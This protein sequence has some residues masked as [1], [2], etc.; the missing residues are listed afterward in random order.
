MNYSF[1]AEVV[2]SL[3]SFVLVRAPEALRPFGALL[4]VLIPLVEFSVGLGLLTRKFRDAAV[5]LAFASHLFI[6][7]LFIPP[8]RNTVVWP[9]N[10]A[11]PALVFILFWRGRN[12]SARDIL[13]NGGR[14]F[15]V[16]AL[17]LFLLAPALGLFGHW[18]SYLSAALYAGNTQRATLR[19]GGPVRDALPPRV[20]RVVRVTSEGA[21]LSVTRWSYAELNVP[22]YPEP[23]IFRRVARR[24]CEYA[25]DP[26]DVVL[27][28]RGRPRILDGARDEK[29]YNCRDL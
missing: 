23:R 17:A 9:W 5:A 24:L 16:L 15:H 2:P 29:T 26:E 7:A 12:F 4:G 14:A 10:V 3:T 18:D 6:L 11:M 1:A 25:A 21:M 13:W 19:I 28:V 20:Q 27:T 8:V 22:P